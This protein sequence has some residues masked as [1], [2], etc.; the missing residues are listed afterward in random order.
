MKMTQ[1]KHFNS[2]RLILRVLICF[3]LAYSISQAWADQVTPGKVVG[4]TDGDTLTLLDA[5]N[6]QHKIRL[7]GIDSPEKGQPFGQACKKSLSDLAYDRLVAVESSKL[8]RYG[9]VIGKVLVDGMDANLE[10]LRRGCGWHYKKY[11]NEQSLDDRILYN[12]AEESAKA[13]RAGLWADSD[14]V[15]P[16]EWRK[17]GKK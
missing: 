11:Q 15:P 14:P 2:N 5:T 7:A 13:S 4:I 8:D 10:Q 12:A 9:R 17:A 3:T 1:L 16:W 6:T